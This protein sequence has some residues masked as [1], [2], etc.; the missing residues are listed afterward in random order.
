[1]SSVGEE[2]NAESRAVPTGSSEQVYIRTPAEGLL[3][4][5]LSPFPTSNCFRFGHPGSQKPYDKTHNTTAA[6][7]T[8]AL[9]RLPFSGV[10]KYPRSATT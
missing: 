2:E 8:P 3:S 1:M 9:L 5:W 6:P 10:I 4:A 7:T